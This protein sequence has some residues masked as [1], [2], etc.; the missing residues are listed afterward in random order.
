MKLNRRRFVKY[1]FG[2]FL[3][4]TAGGVGLSL[5]K[6]KIVSSQQPLKVLSEREFSILYAFANAILPNT[7]DFPMAQT[8]Q[9]AEGVDSV[10]YRSDQ[11]VQLEFKQVL[12]L[13]ENAFAN[14]VL[15]FNTK[16]FTQCTVEEQVNILESWRTSSIKTQRIAFKALNGLCCGSYFASEKTHSLVGYGGEQVHGHR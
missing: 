5:Q 16:P 10:L 13:L 7:K 15:N 1:G 3:L 9:V 4:L 2:G 12:M 6:T 11:E 8:L 14:F